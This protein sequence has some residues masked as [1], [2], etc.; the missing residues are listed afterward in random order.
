MDNQKVSVSIPYIGKDL[1]VNHCYTGRQRTMVKT[2]V[3]RWQMILEH[4]VRGNILKPMP[5]IWHVRCDGYF[6]DGRSAPDLSNLAKVS[7]DAIAVALE[8]DDKDLRWHDGARC[9]GER[10]PTLE[11]TI[12][13]EDDRGHRGEGTKGE[14]F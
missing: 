7:L 2:H 6:K 8:M 9:F 10:E 12:W 3:R 13:Q 1:S 4:M 14:G 5:G 11:F